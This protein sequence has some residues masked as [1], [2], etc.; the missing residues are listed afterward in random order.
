MP[1]RLPGSVD[2]ATNCMMRRIRGLEKRPG[3]R[4][5]KSDQADYSLAITNPG[6]GSQKFFYVIDRD[7]FE[8]FLVVIDPANTGTARVEVFT[9]IARGNGSG[10]SGNEKAGQKMVLASTTTG[11]NDPLDYIALGGSLV[12]RHRYRVLT[13]TDTSIINNREVETG[14]TGAARDYKLADG[15]TLTRTTTSANNRASWNSFPQ[16]PSSTAAD[17]VTI[18][19]FIFFARDDDLGWPSG[20]YRASSTTTPPWY[21]RIRTEPANSVI[22]YT[23]WP[24]Q[25]KFDGTDFELSFPTWPD[26][27]SGDS[28]T[29]PGP[30][31]VSGPSAPHAIRDLCFFQSRLWFGGYEF[32]DSSQTGD[33]FNLWNNSYVGITDIDPVNVS[34]QS[35]AVTTVDWLIPFDGGIVALTRGSRQFEIRSQGLMSPSTVSI[36][37]TT[38]FQ[39]VDYCPPTKLGNQLYFMG[40]RNGAAIIYEY[41]WQADRASN[42]AVNITRDVEAYIPTRAWT[43][44][45]S[46]LNDMLFTLTTSDPFSVYVNQMQW[47]P[48][49]GKSQNAWHKWTQGDVIFDCFVV[50][51]LLY[52][53]KR[54]NGL[55][56][57]ETVDIDLPLDDDDGNTPTTVNNYSGSGDMGFAIR[58]DSRASYQ[59]SYN[60]TTNVT[61]WTVP[62]KDANIDTIVLG[63]MWD[64]DFEYPPSSGTYVEQRRKGKVLTTA[65]GVT[66]D[67]SGSTTVITV[68]GNYATNGHGDNAPVWIGCSFEQRATLNE[69]FVRLDPAAPPEP[70]LVQFKHLMLRLV[71][72]G[73]LRVE[74]TPQGRDAVTHEYT[75][76]LIGQMTVGANLDLEDYDEFN[77]PCKG[78]A[79]T[80]QIDLVNDSVFPSQVVGG[81]FNAS[82]VPSKQDPTRH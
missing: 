63:Q 14:L 59:G 65:D 67:S 54:K 7:E 81:Q 4:L 33:V 72:T 37:P 79:R 6:H 74:V 82:F 78:A 25:L 47:E 38:S 61:T 45:A 20:W 5:V 16:P 55:F 52:L 73:Y 12:A 18:S 29:N 11:G 43:L 40:E 42:A 64:C 27:Y 44:K 9:L 71:N 34:F 19:D 10:S 58:L 53:L 60:S 23:K 13:V 46:T 77:L 41:L 80:T 15:S 24:V 76:D 28:F 26:R 57:L 30:Q 62:Y 70:G 49:G 17:G 69:Q 68:S 56:Y 3:S 21:T 50:G 22:D 48:N 66:F 8:K 36:L 75:K 2:A 1:E 39:T 31:L 32:L 35:D 51:P